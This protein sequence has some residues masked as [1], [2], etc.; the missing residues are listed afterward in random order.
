[1]IARELLRQGV[2]YM[3]VPDSSPPATDLRARPGEW[4]ITPLG[5]SGGVTL[6]RV[7]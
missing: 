2:G 5:E 7:D 4:G 3:L 1:M 6:Y